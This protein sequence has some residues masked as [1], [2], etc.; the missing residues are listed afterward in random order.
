[1]HEIF[2]RNNTSPFCSYLTEKYF[3]SITKTNQLILFSEI[4]AVYYKKH[5]EHVYTHTG[6]NTEYFNAKASCVL[7]RL[8]SGWTKNQCFILAVRA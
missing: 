7:T 6:Q 8:C 4:I 5:A 2:H 3:V 1:M